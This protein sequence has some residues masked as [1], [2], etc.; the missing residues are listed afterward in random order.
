[1]MRSMHVG[2]RRELPDHRWTD[3]RGGDGDADVS[4]VRAL[5]DFPQPAG[6]DAPLL[7]HNPWWAQPFEV[8]SRA[9]GMPARYAADPSVFLAVIVPLL[10]G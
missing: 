2:E 8:F 1:M 4:G 3:D 5:A 10:F 9:L 6:I 7:L